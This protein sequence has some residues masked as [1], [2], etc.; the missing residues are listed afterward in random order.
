[1]I[2]IIIALACAV[3]CFIGRRQ[4]VKDRAYY[5]AKHQEQF[6]LAQTKY[7]DLS[8]SQMATVTA[9]L[10]EMR[11]YIEEMRR[12]RDMREAARDQR[13]TDIELVVRTIRRVNP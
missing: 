7:C 8:A 2:A 9:E 6:M 10:S 11:S 1:M 5:E 4:S 3:I 12:Y 13:L